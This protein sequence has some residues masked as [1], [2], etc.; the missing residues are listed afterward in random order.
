M[1]FSNK[2]E[3]LSLP[4]QSFALEDELEGFRRVAEFRELPGR[5][6][7]QHRVL[8]G[9]EENRCGCQTEAERPDLSVGSNLST[10]IIRG[11]KINTS[12]NPLYKKK[13]F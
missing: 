1:T 3:I 9:G 12:P 10:I 4:G 11:G 7:P 13:N 8:L 5:H 2:M 6:D